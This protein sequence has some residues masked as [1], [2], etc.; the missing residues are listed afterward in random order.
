MPNGTVLMDSLVLVFY[1]NN[2][3]VIYIYSLMS[4]FFSQFCLNACSTDLQK[5]LILY[6][7]LYLYVHAHDWQ[8]N[9]LIFIHFISTTITNELHISNDPLSK[10]NFCLSCW[11]WSLIHHVIKRK[12]KAEKLVWSNYSTCRKHWGYKNCVHFVLN[13]C[14]IKH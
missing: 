4:P 9:I 2:W 10:M 7:Y 6:M 3:L 12:L 1:L 14:R 5:Y 8:I 11:H 13:S